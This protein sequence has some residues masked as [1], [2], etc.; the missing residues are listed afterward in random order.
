MYGRLVSYKGVVPQPGAGSDMT[1]FLSQ[2]LDQCPYEGQRRR[3]KV[4]HS[5]LPV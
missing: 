1:V 2:A 5:F 4:L 3:V